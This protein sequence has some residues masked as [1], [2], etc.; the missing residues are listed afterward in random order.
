MRMLVIVTTVLCLLV[1]ST[2]S[3]QEAPLIAPDATVERI[4]TGFGFLEG[5]AA[6]ADGTLYFTDIPNSRIH[7]WTLTA[8]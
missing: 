1:S 7:R 8:A 5:P 4:A 3:A 2:A 6:D